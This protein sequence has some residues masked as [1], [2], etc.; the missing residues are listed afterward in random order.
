M[1]RVYISLIIAALATSQCALAQESL[2]FEDWMDYKATFGTVKV[3]GLTTNTITVLLEERE[4][5]EI[6]TYQIREDA[7]FD[8]VKQFEEIEEGDRVDFE[9]YV[10]KDGRSVIDFI[11]VTKREEEIEREIFEY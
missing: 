10:V 7:E 6:V 5:G 8:G 3:V 2:Q 4:G 1:K 11:S 9:Y